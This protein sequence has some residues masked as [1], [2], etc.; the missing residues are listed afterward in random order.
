MGT[1]HRLLTLSIA[2]MLIA[3]CSGA[4]SP[5][6]ATQAAS[7]AS[8]ATATAVPTTAASAAS[9]APSAS[10]AAATGAWQ[11]SD[12]FKDFDPLKVDLTGY[13]PGPNGEHSTN[14]ADV[15]DPTAACLSQVKGK[16]VAFLNGLSGNSWMAAI[17][18]GVR[19]K[20]AEYGLKVVATAS[21]DFDPAKEAAAVETVMASKPDILITIPVD[22]ASGAADY[23]PAV[24]AG[25]TLSFYD[26]PVTGYTAGKEYVAIT[27]GDHYRM[28]KDAA[29]LLAQA[30]GGKGKYGFIQLDVVFYNSN[31]REKGFLA[32]MAQKYPD[33]QNV[34]W[35]GF[36]TDSTVGAATDAMLTQHPD[37]D[38]IYVSYS[39]GPATAVLA[40]LQAANNT[41]VKV[42]THDLDAANDVIMAT[43]GSNYYGTA[44]EH[45]YDEGAGTVKAAV[46][47]LCGETVPP[48][49]VVPALAVNRDNLAQAW[50][51][52]WHQTPPA[53]VTAALGK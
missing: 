36:T 15:P 27:T 32:E 2:G 31:N 24:D 10:A 25:V 43:K 23:K 53:E 5:A 42:V 19:E 33:M 35:A 28:G 52:A 14:A 4:A 46:L 1:R 38:G 16:K 17:E 6:P 48:F 50:A 7:S 45:T 13:T 40:S 30:L 41:H 20:S 26:N 29:D 3:G 44:I 34:A 21:T 51:E 47:K 11:Q 22:P 37:L 39:G 8:A 18:K 9:S 49:I 12:I